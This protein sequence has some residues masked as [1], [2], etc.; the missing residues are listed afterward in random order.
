MSLL[1]LSQS[2]LRLYHLRLDKSEQGNQVQLRFP[3]N[4]LVDGK[5][6]L[7][8]PIHLKS[9]FLESTAYSD[10]CLGL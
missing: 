1:C 2:I 6:E 5:E 10:S 3:A 8:N 9:S 4:D 7:E